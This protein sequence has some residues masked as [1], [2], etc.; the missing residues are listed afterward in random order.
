MKERLYR[1][2]KELNRPYDSLDKLV[3]R[4][5]SLMIQQIRMDFVSF[6]L[7]NPQ[8]LILSMELV[9]AKDSWLEID[10]EIHLLE[11][12]PLWQLTEGKRKYLLYHSPYPILYVPLKWQGQ[13]PPQA[14]GVLRLERTGSRRSFTARERLLAQNFAEE[15]AQN[16]HQAQTDQKNRE[17]LNRVSTLTNLTEI[18][19]S[20]LRVEDG[21]KLILQGIQQYFGFDRVRLYLVDRQAQKLKGE[22]SADIRGQ[23]KSLS[24]EEIPMQPGVHRFVDL[25]LGS[26]PDPLLERYKDTVLYIPLKVQGQS[27]GLLIVDNLLSQQSIAQEDVGLLRSFA[28]QIA[29]AVD[30]ARLFDEVQDLSLYDALTQLPLRRYF[31]QRFQE[32]IY[33]AERFNQPLALLWLDIDY[34]KQIND[35]Y[36]HQ[37][38]DQVIKEVGRIILKNL[39][40]IDFPCRYG[41]D[42]VLI[43]LPQAKEEEAKAIASR[44]VQEIRDL[45]MPVKFSTSQVIQASVSLGIATFPGDAGSLEE[46]MQRADEALYWV[47]SHGKNGVALYRETVKTSQ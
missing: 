16:F 31:M 33:R 4:A 35:T 18:F 17:Q 36:G 45:R 1:F 26:G 32:E 10:E 34:F 40:K 9:L 44:L 12:S 43:L 11:G 41:G 24:H 39:R 30:N 2:H 25:V 22:L 6:F 23:V 21:L 42:E 28:G 14:L 20:S 15:L 38:G 13:T 47:K 37:L 46:L 5:L 29:L 7:L 3:T 19:A 8:E 27:T